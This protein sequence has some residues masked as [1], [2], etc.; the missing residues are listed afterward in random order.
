ME[1]QENSTS[2]SRNSAENLYELRKLVA[3]MMIYYS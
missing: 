2:G 3:D 1:L